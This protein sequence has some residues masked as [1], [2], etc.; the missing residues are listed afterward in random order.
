MFSKRLFLTVA[1][2]LVVLSL[3]ACTPTPAPPTEAPTEAPT[4]EPTEAPTEEPTEEGPALGSA[5]RPI[6]VYFVPSVEVDQIISGGEVLR[7]ALTDATGLEFEVFVPTS[8]AAAIEGMCAAQEDTMGFPATL[9]YVI[10]NARCGF[11]AS[12]I[13]NR[14][15]Y[16]EYASM[17]LVPRDSEIESIAELDGLKWA[18]GDVGSTSGYLFPTLTLALNSVTASEEVATGGHTQSILALYNGEVDFATSYF[19]P[20]LPSEESG[21][22]RW[23]YG[24]DPEPYADVVDECVVEIVDESYHLYCG[25]YEIK[26]ARNR[27]SVLEV[28]D[29]AVMTDVRVLALSDTAPND[30]MAFGADFDPALRAQIEQAITGMIGTEAWDDSL[31]SFYNYTSLDPVTDVRYQV[32]RDGLEAAGLSMDDII[33][34]LD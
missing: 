26:D 15:G 17:F 10:A 5:E 29:A 30:C 13:A 25:D 1:A 33:G 27:S 34:Y 31:G 8:Y 18:Y 7:Q 2:A 4:E 6:Q 3:A 22:D 12:M 16:T 9:A 28:T 32:V 14:D 11:D 24:D 20:P 21:L 23:A 19:N